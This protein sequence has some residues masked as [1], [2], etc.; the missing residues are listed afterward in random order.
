MKK[1][2]LTTAVLFCL[3]LSTLSAFNV[4]IVNARQC[5]ES[6]KAGQAEQALFEDLKKQLEQGIE[7]KEKELHELKPKLS[8]EYLDTQTPEAENQIKERAQML[9][10][11]LQELYYNMSM[12]LNKANYDLMQKLVGLI[13][14]ASKTTAEAK[15]LDLILNEDACF[16]KAP[17]I[18]ITADVVRNLDLLFETNK[19]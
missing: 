3:Q 19:Q 7:K 12:V 5:I 9:Q 2:I 11:E 16:Y 4:G 10:Q 15:K 1:N 13:Q 17:S 8:P 6:S 14:H 18:D